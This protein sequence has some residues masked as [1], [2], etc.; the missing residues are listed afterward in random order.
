M[1]Q[2]LHMCASGSNFDVSVWK[3]CSVH[4]AASSEESPPPLDDDRDGSP[5]MFT[6]NRAAKSTSY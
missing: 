5:M 2:M 3:L 6:F 4:G 1:R